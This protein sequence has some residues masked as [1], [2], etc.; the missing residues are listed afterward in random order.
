MGEQCPLVLYRPYSDPQNPHPRSPRS[1]PPPQ[2]PYPKVAS[3]QKTQGFTPTL[4]LPPNS[5]PFLLIIPTRVPG[6]PPWRR[7]YCDAG[8]VLP[9]PLVSPRA[10][11]GMHA[12]VVMCACGLLIGCSPGLDVLLLLSCLVLPILDFPLCCS[13][14]Q[15]VVRCYAAAYVRCI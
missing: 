10:V 14:L 2:F 9:F 1:S 12:I 3:L 11:S 13:S 15:L 7:H 6:T 8:W 5:L 4:S